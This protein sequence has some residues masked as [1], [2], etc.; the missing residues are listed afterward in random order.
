MLEQIQPWTQR[1][2]TLGHITPQAEAKRARGPRPWASSHLEL[3]GTHQSKQP[4]TPLH[5][6]A[7]TPATSKNFGG[8][9]LGPTFDGGPE[10]H[11]NGRRT[12]THNPH[13]YSPT[14]PTMPQCNN[15]PGRNTNQLSSTVTAQPIQM[16][17]TTHPGRGEDDTIPHPISYNPSTPPWT[18]HPSPPQTQQPAHHQA[19]PTTQ[20]T[21]AA[22]ACPPMREKNK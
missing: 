19:L 16:P 22:P 12:L 20:P 9:E 1:P 6:Q 17:V 5:Q 10:K 21:P 14:A 3:A 11:N 18:N 4:R 15:S 2:K 8:E 7:E 13:T